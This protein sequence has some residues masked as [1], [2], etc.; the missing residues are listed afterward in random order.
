MQGHCITFIYHF[1]M[2]TILLLLIMTLKDLT[3]PRYWRISQYAAGAGL[4]FGNDRN[5]TLQCET[6]STSPNSRLSE[7]AHVRASLSSV[8][9]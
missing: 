4:G 8:S 5:R 1:A 3:E 6:T 2:M 7:L 9:L